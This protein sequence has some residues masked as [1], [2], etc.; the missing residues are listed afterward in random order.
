MDDLSPEFSQ[1]FVLKLPMGTGEGVSVDLKWLSEEIQRIDKLFD[2]FSESHKSLIKKQNP[3]TELL[4][5]Q[6]KVVEALANYQIA[7]AEQQNKRQGHIQNESEL[8]E[9]MNQLDQFVKMFRDN[10]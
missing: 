4:K 6:F 7:L 2:E 5:A 8:H 1:P 9:M 10:K 3:P